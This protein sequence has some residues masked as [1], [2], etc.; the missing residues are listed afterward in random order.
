MTEKEAEHAI[1]TCHWRDDRLKHRKDMREVICR[2]MCLP[3][4]RAIEL[5]KCDA[6]LDLIRKERIENG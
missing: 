4:L 2:G 1:R 6:L 5:G 3:C